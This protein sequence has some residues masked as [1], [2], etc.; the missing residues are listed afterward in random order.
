MDNRDFASRQGG[1]R[2]KIVKLLCKM[3]GSCP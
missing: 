3:L 1:C 2:E